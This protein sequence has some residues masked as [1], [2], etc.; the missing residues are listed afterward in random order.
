MLFGDRNLSLKVIWKGG[1]EQVVMGHNR[2]QENVSQEKEYAERSGC[3][4]D[5]VA[6][7][8]GNDLG[9]WS[10]RTFEHL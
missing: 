8:C 4:R 3:R 6:L 1:I 7:R 10:S 9:S 2:V 5:N